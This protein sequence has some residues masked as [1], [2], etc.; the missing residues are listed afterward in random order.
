MRCQR[1]LVGTA[2]ERGEILPERIFPVFRDEEE[3]ATGNLTRRIYEAL[4]QSKVLVVLC[5]AQAVRSEYVA[6]EI[7]YFKHVRG[8]AASARNVHAAIIDGDPNAAPETGSQCFPD[9]LRYEVHEGVALTNRP[10]TP[11]SADFRLAD[12]SEGWTSPEAYRH[13]LT[14][15]LPALAAGEIERLVCSYRERLRNG[16]LKLISGVLGVPYRKLTERDKAY[17]LK[18]AR[19]AAAHQSRDLAR[20]LHDQDPVAALKEALKALAVVEADDAEAVHTTRDAVAAIVRAGRLARIGN[21]V[22]SVHPM[23]DGKSMLLVHGD[24]VAELVRTADLRTRASLRTV[25]D[26]STPCGPNSSWRT[27]IGPKGLTLLDMCTGKRGLQ[28]LSDVREIVQPP[29]D[30]YWKAVAAYNHPRAM[31]SAGFGLCYLTSINDDD[32]WASGDSH[33]ERLDF[34]SGEI[35]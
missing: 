14:A 2:N 30:E 15:Q 21:N 5:S 10:V 27:L 29:H 23:Q 6:E 32:E 4:D 33:V 8:P 35:S 28:R 25:Q 18:R 26:I 16:L 17:Q 31:C 22:H 7:R 13:A 11:L 3:L 1:I 9:A 24:G 19:I 34:H 12:G 20:V